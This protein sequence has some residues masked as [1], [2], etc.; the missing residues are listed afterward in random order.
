MLLL[1]LTYGLG[2]LSLRKMSDVTFR[3]HDASDQR[4]ARLN[5]L[6]DLRLK[7]TQL[8]NEARL[9]SR[10]ESGS[11]Q[12]R[13]DLLPPFEF[14]LNNARAEVAEAMRRLEGPPL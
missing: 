7:V 1:G 14:R 3:A 5:L 4:I 13:R 2:Y 12:Q 6:F 11:E 8:D 10:T 9:R